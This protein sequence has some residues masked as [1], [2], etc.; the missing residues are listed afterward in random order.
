MKPPGRDK[1]SALLQHDWPVPTVFVSEII[2]EK[3]GLTP[4]GKKTYTLIMDCLGYPF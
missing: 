1:T 2:N 4:A 3:R